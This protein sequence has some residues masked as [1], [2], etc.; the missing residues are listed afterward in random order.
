MRR[1]GGVCNRL[2][3]D[4][5]V[6]RLDG[7]PRQEAHADAGCLPAQCLLTDTSRVRWNNSLLAGVVDGERADGYY[8]SAVLAIPRS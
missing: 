3:Y 4:A 7:E 8:F 5:R 1:P 2:D 6:D